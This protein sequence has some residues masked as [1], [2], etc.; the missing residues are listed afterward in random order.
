MRT[1]G[2]LPAAQGISAMQ[3]INVV[4]LNPWFLTPFVGTAVGCAGVLVG[5]LL[6]P[7]MPA[8]LCSVAAS[9]L[10]LG[11]NL[12]VTRAFNIPRNDALAT[13]VPTSPEAV[14]V[15]AEYLASWSAW[16]H[17]RAITGTLAA[18]LFC[19]ALWLRT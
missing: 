7:Q 18:L 6:S 10:Y 5:S 4:V 12:V 2:G 19:A 17:V 14:A 15:W 8:S 3:S 9:L 13:L 16:N 1:L 11:G